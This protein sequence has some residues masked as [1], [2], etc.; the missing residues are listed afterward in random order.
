M[1]ELRNYRVYEVWDRFLS[2]GLLDLI[3]SFLAGVV[4][5]QTAKNLQKLE[6]DTNSK[7][8]NDFLQDDGNPKWF[9]T[10]DYV[11]S[12]NN[13]MSRI[14]LRVFVMIG[15]VA[16]DVFFMTFIQMVSFIITQKKMKCRRSPCMKGKPRFVLDMV[17]NEQADELLAHTPKIQVHNVCMKYMFILDFGLWI[18]ATTLAIEFKRPS[19]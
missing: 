1:S 14:Q 3:Q 11:N 6:K 15:L 17:G 16:M 10:L 9:I 13:E 12:I 5:L 7:T 8:F 18:G 4:V 19:D 2:A